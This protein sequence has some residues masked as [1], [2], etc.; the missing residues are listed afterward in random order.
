MSTDNPFAAPTSGDLEDLPNIF[1]VEGDC[2]LCGPQTDVSAVCWLTGERMTPEQQPTPLK[3]RLVYW[4]PWLRRTFWILPA[5]VYLIS[6]LLLGG[7]LGGA[8]T[9]IYSWLLIVPLVFRFRPGVRL[10]AA[11]SSR[12]RQLRWKHN[13]RQI[14]RLLTA[15]VCAIAASRY[16][17]SFFESLPAELE[18]FA[19]V[20]LPVLVL[21]LILTGWEYVFP[22]AI[23]PKRPVITEVHNN[24]YRIKDAPEPFLSGLK[25]LLEWPVLLESDD[26]QDGLPTLGQ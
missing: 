8:L 17:G 5:G 1:R 13:L 20:L 15:I 24:I 10:E 3:I 12:G 7:R 25:R 21:I 22:S 6:R 23:R 11:L 18:V 16:C 26:S 9:A 14:A 19:S 4:P 2:L